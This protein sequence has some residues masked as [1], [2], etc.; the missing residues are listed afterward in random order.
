MSRIVHL[1]DVVLG[2]G[3]QM[4]NQGSSQQLHVCRPARYHARTQHTS[5]L[6][7]LTESA[8][9]H[10]PSSLT[11]LTCSLQPAGA[12][13]ISPLVALLGPRLPEGS[14]ATRPCTALL[15]GQNGPPLHFHSTAVPPSPA[16]VPQMSSVPH[17][18]RLPALWRLQ[19]AQFVALSVA[20][21]PN[22]VFCH[23]DQGSAGP[24]GYRPRV[25]N[26]LQTLGR[27]EGLLGPYPAGIRSS[28]CSTAW[29]AA[30]I[31]DRSAQP[32]TNG[33]ARRWPS[34]VPEPKWRQTAGPGSPCA[35]N[36]LPATSCTQGPAPCFRHACAAICT[37]PP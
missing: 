37:A 25:G 8:Y 16:S 31:R 36:P 13:C 1:Q 18:P 29:H 26:R 32:A 21:C 12:S 6:V 15:L 3:C 14:S 30:W 33:T 5:G 35:G 34:C 11:V 20:S 27:N 28:A 2:Q 7:M 4:L 22:R 9:H 23:L 19:S 17:A 10:Y 24:A